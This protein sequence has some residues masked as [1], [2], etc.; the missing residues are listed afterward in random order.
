MS[1][2]DK[3]KYDR[4]YYLANKDKVKIR[5]KSWREANK[6]DKI[7][8]DR[9]YYLENKENICART[10]AYRKANIEKVKKYN[11]EYHH[12][13]RDAKLKYLQEYVATHKEQKKEYDKYYYH[14]N[15]I[16]VLKNVHA[17]KVRRLNAEGT[18]TKEEIINLYSSQG[19][20]CYYCS[21]NIESGYHI[22]HMTPLSRGGSNWID[23]ICL[24]C[25]SC[26]L[27]KQAKTVKEFMEYNVC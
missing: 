6:N 14:N 27:S 17:Y 13:N 24:S 4:L 5:N 16:K 12:I 23:N 7:A 10:K 25:A 21:V 19:A 18:F 20:R 3:R 2:V 1:K 9:L 15:K 11:R 26:N 8:G 22:E